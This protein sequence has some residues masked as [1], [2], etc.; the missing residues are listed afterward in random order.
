T[1]RFT[2]VAV[3]RG[4]RPAARRFVALSAG[5]GHTCALT[6][7]AGLYCWGTNTNG[8]LGDGTLRNR[9]VPVASRRGAIRPAERLIQVRAGM[10]RTC[11]LTNHGNVYCQG[12][13]GQ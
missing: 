8:Q 10:Y 6:D 11:L 4:A 13:E 3:H 12:R 9:Y 2:P 5:E 1:E 7:H